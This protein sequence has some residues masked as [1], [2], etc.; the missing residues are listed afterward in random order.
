MT[1]WSEYENKDN[2]STCGKKKE[3]KKKKK[4]NIKCGFK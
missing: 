3:T 2:Q 1:Y 4:I